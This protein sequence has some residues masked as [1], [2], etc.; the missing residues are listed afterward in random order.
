M[1]MNRS[2]T[3]SNSKNY[4][5][6]HGGGCYLFGNINNAFDGNMLWHGRGTDWNHSHRG[7]Y[8]N[9]ALL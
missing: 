4:T 9:W 8:Y 3:K 6:G 2:D 5:D 7:G 1:N